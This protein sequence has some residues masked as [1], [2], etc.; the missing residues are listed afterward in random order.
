[1]ADNDNWQIF[2]NFR[3]IMT[4]ID[5]FLPFLS[6]TG[7]K[8]YWPISSNFNRFWPILIGFH[9]FYFLGRF[10]PISTDFHRFWWKARLP[11]RKWIKVNNSSNSLS[12]VFS[13]FGLIIAIVFS[14]WTGVYKF[15]CLQR[16]INFYLESVE[17]FIEISF[18]AVHFVKNAWI[19]IKLTF[20]LKR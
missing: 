1:M 3:P 15:I 9:D 8:Q 5:R 16:K 7:F 19:G 6:V 13:W 20:L 11:L 10:W 2:T 14:I 18:W 12:T 4:E 17:F